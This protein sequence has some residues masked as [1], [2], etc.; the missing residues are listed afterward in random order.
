MSIAQLQLPGIFA[1]VTEMDNPFDNV[2]I[3]IR[4]IRNNSFTQIEACRQFFA[5]HNIPWSWFVTPGSE[6]NDLTQHGF[7]FLEE[8]PAMYFDLY[9][10]IPNLKSASITIQEASATDDLQT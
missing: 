4:E 9:T 3:D 1:S 10:P 7:S 2:V 6:N 5:Q 8:V